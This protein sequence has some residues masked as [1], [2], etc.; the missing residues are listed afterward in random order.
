V[1]RRLALLATALL[2]VA[3]SAGCSSDVSP[4]ARIG[5]V[6]ISNDD[7]LAEVGEWAGNPAAVSP[8]ELAG[9]PPGTYPQALVAQVLQQRIDLELH[10]QEFAHLH[11]KLTDD[12]RQQALTN[13]FGDPQAAQQALGGFSEDFA[14]SYIDDVVRQTEVQAELG[15]ADYATWHDEA[16]RTTK[17]EVNSRYGSWDVDSGSIVAPSGPKQPANAA[18]DLQLGS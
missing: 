6:K 9:Q 10:N 5:D 1:P 2:T 18:T 4:A 17:I 12:L 13:L 11:L 16:V 7:F 15:D 8:D 14:A 3:F